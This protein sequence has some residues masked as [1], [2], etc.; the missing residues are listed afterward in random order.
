MRLLRLLL[1]TFMLSA[2]Q[3]SWAQ[4]QTE[5]P[6][7]PAVEVDLSKSVTIFPNPATDFI[8]VKVTEFPVE[9]VGITLRNILG[10][11]MHV[12]RE[13]ISEN[14]IRLRVNDLASGYYLLAVKEED[15]QYRGTFKFV[16]K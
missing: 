1:V 8:T 5:E 6:V 2:A 3:W 11:E 9:K 10:N 13:I 14:E 4:A 15:S 7:R 12:E 16:K